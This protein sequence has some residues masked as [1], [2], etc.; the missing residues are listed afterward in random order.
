MNSLIEISGVNEGSVSRTSKA[1]I[2]I[3]MVQGI[4]EKTR[5]VALGVLRNGVK[6]PKN[7]TLTNVTLTNHE[8]QEESSE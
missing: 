7:T 6:A 2:E 5:Q 3:L 8:S 1:I 4:S